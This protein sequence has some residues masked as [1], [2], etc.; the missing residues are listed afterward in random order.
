VT[1]AE[2]L[3]E[4]QQTDDTIQS[5]EARL[6]QLEA[7]L[8]ETEEL[9]ATRSRLETAEHELQALESRQ[10]A[11]ELDLRSI[12]S[13][14]ASEESRLYGGRVTNPKE[15]AGL[16]KEVTYLKGRREQLQDALLD[17]MMAREE[18]AQRVA[19]RRSALQQIEA[20]W[21]EEQSVLTAERYRLQS[22]LGRAYAQRTELVEQVP[23]DALSTYDYLRRTRGTAVAPVENGTCTGCQVRLSAV[24]RRRVHDAELMTCSNCGRVLVV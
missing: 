12:E 5:A 8:G 22:E 6:Q 10:R 14:I 20:A 4:L 16:Q 23:P 9:Q 21:Q 2:T 3:Y 1:T 7:E 19:E 18:T 24:D 17:T 15:L 13:K 11:Q